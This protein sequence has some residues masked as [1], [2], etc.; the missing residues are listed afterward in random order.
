VYQAPPVR[1]K[2]GGFRARLGGFLGQCTGCVLAESI[3]LRSSSCV[4]LSLTPPSPSPSSLLLQA[5]S[6]W[7]PLVILSCFEVGAY[8]T[9]LYGSL[10]GPLFERS[11]L[12]RPSLTHSFYFLLRPSSLPLRLSRRCPPSDSEHRGVVYSGCDG[13]Q[14]RDRPIGAP[15]RG[16]REGMQVGQ[17]NDERTIPSTAATHP[18]LVHFLH[19]SHSLSR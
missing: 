15:G 17:V 3:E 19:R 5:A 12:A 1:E 4:L 9:E 13:T 14:I 7:P 2:R 16:T 6:P 8:E 18:P 11:A 10:A